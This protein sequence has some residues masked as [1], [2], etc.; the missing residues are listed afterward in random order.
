MSF[1]KTE[2]GAL[3]LLLGTSALLLLLG[4]CSRDQ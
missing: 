3:V 2:R 1:W 4:L